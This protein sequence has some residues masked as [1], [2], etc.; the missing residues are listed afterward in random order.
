[1]HANQHATH[2]LGATLVAAALALTGCATGTATLTSQVQS[3]SSMQGIALPATYRMEILPSQAQQE[4]FSQIEYAAQAALERVGLHRDVRPDLARLVVQVGASAT[5]AR[6][7]HPTFDPY[8]YGPRFGWGVGY[9]GGWHSHWG[10][11]WM[12]AD[13]PPLVQVRAVKLV[14]RDAQS[15]RIVYETSAQ[16]DE[17]RL[18]EARIWQ[19]LFEAALTGFPFPPAG[20]RQVTAPRYA[21]PAALPS[22]GDSTAPAPAPAPAAPAAHSTPDITIPDEAVEVTPVPLPVQLQP[23]PVR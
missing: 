13:V 4:S 23:Q 21:A 19:V 11:N 6:A 16:Y 12:M 18:D 2:W 20:P 5:Q 17:V 22:V 9:G 3:Y 7:Q 8:Y 15:Q 1:M 14:L 10:M